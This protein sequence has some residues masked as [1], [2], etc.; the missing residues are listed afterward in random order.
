MRC[1]GPHRQSDTS[2]FEFDSSKAQLLR[3]FSNSDFGTRMSSRTVRWECD[4]EKEGCG[5]DWRFEGVLTVFAVASACASVSF[6]IDAAFDSSG[7]IWLVCAEVVGKA[8]SVGGW[9][10][11]VVRVAMFNKSG[12][13][14]CVCTREN[15][16]RVDCSARVLVTRRASSNNHFAV[17]VSVLAL[18]RALVC[19]IA[20]SSSR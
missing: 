3:M 19:C 12:E 14:L 8:G 10:C 2:S 4:N 16:S 5:D 6:P 20:K 17:S 15:R 18:T 7:R 1:K 13:H 9:C 11:D